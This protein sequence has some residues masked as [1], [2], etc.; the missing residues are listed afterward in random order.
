MSDAD[1]LEPRVAIRVVRRR[2]LADEWALVLAAEG[3]RAGV[4]GGPDGFAVEVPASDG[5]RA[6]R[7]LAAFERENRIAP[8]PPEPPPLDRTPLLHASVV[9]AALLATFAW[10][11]PNGGWLAERGAAQASAIRAGEWWRAVTALVLHADAGHVLGN[12]IAGA[13]FLTAVFRG[14]GPGFGGALALAAGAFGNLANAWLRDPDHTTIGASTAVFGALG[15]LVGERMVRRRATPTRTAAW[16]PLGAGL[17]L[18]AMLGTEG[19]RVDVGAHTF[20]LAAGIVLGLAAARLPAAW[21][22]RPLVQLAAGLG[23]IA[24]IAGAC[25]LAVR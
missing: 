24:V 7:L 4:C 25:A 17:A 6:E 8:P 22:A 18:L 5:D 12:A 16:I 15:V 11:G 1:E 13:L 2:A 14:F 3:V 19:D 20:G 9:S 23:A 10:T 21:L